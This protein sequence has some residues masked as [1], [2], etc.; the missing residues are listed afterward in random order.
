ME[1]GTTTLGLVV[2]A[3][4][5]ANLP[6]FT[7]RRLGV[8]LFGQKTLKGCLLEWLFFYGL[9]LLLGFILE[10]RYSTHTVQGW[11]FYAATLCLFAVLAF[12]GFIWRTLW[13]GRSH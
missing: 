8:F 3:L 2:V 12:P 13:Y 1:H 9:F 10:S 6:F 7:N 11:S 5:A 4:L